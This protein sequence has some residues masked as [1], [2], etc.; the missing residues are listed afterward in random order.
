MASEDGDRNGN[1][2]RGDHAV[3]RTGGV[4]DGSDRSAPWRGNAVLQPHV[5][6]KAGLG[7][8]ADGDSGRIDPAVGAMYGRGPY[9]L[10]FDLS[11]G[12]GPAAFRKRK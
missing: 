4:A 5:A 7:R 2:V 6:G 10:L 12:S 9:G 1:S 3:H 11:G 8:R